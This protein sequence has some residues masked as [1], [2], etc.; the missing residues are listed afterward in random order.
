MDLE[1]VSP[2]Y[3]ECPLYPFNLIEMF[4]LLNAATKNKNKV[5][6]F[7]KHK[8][9]SNKLANICK[10]RNLGQHHLTSGMRTSNISRTNVI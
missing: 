7:C 4:L 1:I 9:K 6:L 3:L 8:R 10:C 5:N 2:F